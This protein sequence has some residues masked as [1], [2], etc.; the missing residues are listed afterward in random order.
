[1]LLLMSWPGYPS[2]ARIPRPDY[3]SSFFGATAT[4]V[5]G[6]LLRL[7]ASLGI[8][9]RLAYR[10]P[11]VVAGTGVLV[12]VVVAGS[13]FGRWLSVGCARLIHGGLP[14]RLS[15]LRGILGGLPA[16]PFT[17]CPYTTLTARVLQVEFF[18]ITIKL[19]LQIGGR[20]QIPNLREVRELRGL[21][22]KEL[23]GVSGVSLRSVAGYEG[24][25]Q[26]RP[27]TARKLA[28]ALNV[29]VADL[30]EASSYPKAQAPPSPEQ[31]SFNGLL[32]EERRTQHLGVWTRYLRQRVEWC[33]KVLQK[34]PEDTFNN[35][36]LSLDAAIQWAIYVGAESTQLQNAL[37]N[38]VR[39][40]TDADS[41]II[42]ELRTLLDRFVIV[43]DTTDARVKAMMDEAGLT[44]E[45]KEQRLR[46]IHGNAA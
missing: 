11:A 16:G 6:E 22:Q 34:S 3:L 42:G 15:G 4:E 40:Y 20:V 43:E 44:D 30:A 45:D 13:F 36:F 7:L 9:N 12:L 18:Y 24:G 21:T 2:E 8:D 19:E 33:E 46:L 14:S 41:E 28:Q 26:V 35:P 27:N 32:E 29:E 25:A 37:R 10:H 1:M 31:P 23:A 17:L 39:S 38:E 5:Q